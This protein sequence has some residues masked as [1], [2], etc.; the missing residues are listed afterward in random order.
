M[1]KR[2]I[3]KFATSIALAFALISCNKESDLGSS[4]NPDTALGNEFTINLLQTKTINDG[5]STKWVVGDLVNVFHAEAGTDNYI[6]DGAF[7]YTENAFRGYI[8]EELESDK[9]Y[10]WYVSY[11]YDETMESPK[12]MRINIPAIQTQAADGDMS[13]LCGSLCPLVGK[14]RNIRATEEPSIMMNHLVT[15][16]K[17]KVTNYEAEPCNLETV[18]FCHHTKEGVKTILSGAY[19]VDMTGGTIIYKRIEEAD[20]ADGDNGDLTRPYIRLETPKVLGLNESAIVYIV[21]L[22]FTIEN[23][24]RLCIGMN[25][26]QGGV[27]QSIYG[28]SPVCR[29][30]AINGVKQGSRLAPPF[31]S[32]INFYCGKKLA[33]G[34]YTM[35][36]KDWW[37]CELPEGYDL[38]RSFDFK[39]LFTTINTDAK[40]TLIAYENQNATVKSKYEDFESCLSKDGLWNGMAD[41][42]LNLDFPEKDRSGVFIN[43]SAGY[44]VGSWAIMYREFDEEN[45]IKPDMSS[46]PYDSYLGLVMAGYQGWHGTP[47]DG[48]PHNPAEGWPHYAS[49]VQHPFIFEPGVLR[50]NIDFWPD[51]SEY[52]RTYAAEGFTCP[53]GSTP[54]LYSSYDKSTVRLHFKWMKEYG[55][56]G[57][58]MQRFAS[59]LMDNIAVQHSDKVLESAMEASNEYARAISIMYDM[60]GLNANTSVNVI[61]DDAA[62]LIEKYNIKD[63]NSAQ[64]Y[65]LYHNGKP[66][67]G[68]VS[69]GQ[70]SAP[71]TVAQAQAIVDGLQEMG[72]SIM[73]GVPAYWKDAEKG[74]GDVVEDTALITLIKDVD[75]IMPWFVGAYD[76]NGS[77]PSTPKGSFTNFFNERIIGENGD[78]AKAKEFGV[79]YCPLVFPGF[80]DRNMHP[81]HFVYDRHDGNFYWQQ[82]YKYINQGA[83]M[84]YVAMFDEI[85][86]GTAIYKCLRKN[87]V[88]S[89]TYSQDYYVVSKKGS[90]YRSDEAVEVSGNDWCTKASELNV[91]FNGI[92]NNRASDYYLRLTGEAAKILKGKVTLTE[93]KPF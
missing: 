85:D 61:L 5:M 27:S 12:S 22:P 37:R 15:V 33:D 73:L 67:I 88:P 43:S 44:N 42:D 56:D 28:T 71:Y 86:E 74:G 57:V 10:D 76:Y 14:S 21:C 66:L 47:G 83:Q 60:V 30:G 79:E 8:H 16:M 70:N 49:V 91:T 40:F 48:C 72:F 36:N 2:Y 35:D 84:L 52:K 46:A 92:E 78:F 39:T 54:R 23:G 62:R 81:K 82:I 51:V 7:I 18:S 63:R 26:T 69:V 13:H 87:E 4:S 25:N 19:H 80:S 29:A 24:T 32:N 34:T 55:I 58:F 45:H 59:Q 41:I 9:M 93:T 89:N 77:V 53:D 20:D 64:R 17:V 90:L 1:K 65:Y 68:L 50:N 11:P 31:K 38:Q 75:I 3:L 6:C